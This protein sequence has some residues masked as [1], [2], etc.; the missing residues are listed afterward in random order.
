MD[1]QANSLVDYNNSA[2]LGKSAPV[3]NVP[4]GF[5]VL[6]TCPLILWLLDGTVAGFASAILIIGLFAVGMVFLSIGQKNH[7]AYDQAEVAA[8]PRVPFKLL[9]SAIVALVVGLLA[10][11]KIGLP[12]VPVLIG[13]ATFILCLVSFGL[14]PMRDKGLNNPVVRLRLAN[15][16]LYQNCEDRFEAILADLHALQDD[17]LSGRARTISD[18]ILGLLAT[19]D[20]ETRTLQKMSGPLEKLLSKMEA[21]TD[22]LLERELSLFERRK[23]QTKMQALA[24]AFEARARK[25][26]IAHGRN[27]FELQADLLFDRMQR[28]RSA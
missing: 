2:A 14:D 11:A 13:C 28:N 3:H 18:T 21:E 16:R 7:L 23:Y 5:M 17:D 25:S 15:Q 26:G 22:A 9:G 1:V 19:V 24:D 4:V 6:A 8:R 10:T 27:S 12:T 20:F